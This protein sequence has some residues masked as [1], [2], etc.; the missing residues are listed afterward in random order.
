MSDTAWIAICAERTARTL[1]DA[2]RQMQDEHPPSVAL[3]TVTLALDA[4]AED[5]R[6]F[7]RHLRS[8]D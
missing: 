4:R 7:A 8:A 2:K 3:T 5:W 6:T 1:E